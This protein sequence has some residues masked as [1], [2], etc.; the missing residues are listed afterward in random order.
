MSSWLT[1]IASK[2]SSLLES[3]DEY[4]AN[5]IQSIVTTATGAEA[6]KYKE[7]S[8]NTNQPLVSLPL[9]H[10][11]KE[12]DWSYPSPEELR[13]GTSRQ[14]L[15]L[16]IPS[17]AQGTDSERAV[18]DEKLLEFL[19]DP[20]SSSPLT[21]LPHILCSAMLLQ[22]CLQIFLSVQHRRARLT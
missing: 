2:A 22:V 6:E 13:D 8:R 20:K 16:E 19:N 4:A 14:P 9:P 5:S 10:T 17:P 1:G 11:Q 15:K 7:N 12:A 21:G 3:V 18:S